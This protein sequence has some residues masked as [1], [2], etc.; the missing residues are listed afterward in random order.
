MVHVSYRPRII[1]TILREALEE[2]GVVWLQGPKW[3]G[4]TWTVSQ[5]ARSILM[6]Q[7]PDESTNHALVN[8]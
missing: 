6:M 4:K 3:F 2:C 8:I 1:D 5:I 7:D